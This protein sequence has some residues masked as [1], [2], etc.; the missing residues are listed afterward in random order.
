MKIFLTGFRKRITGTLLCFLIIAASVL[1]SSFSCAAAVTE[2]SIKA[3]ENQISEAKKE[4]DSLK[5][6]KTDL[7]KIKKSL[8]AS[9]SD[10][11]RFITDLDSQLTD[12]QEKIDALLDKIDQKERQIEKTTEELKEAE[13]IQQAQYEAMKKRIKFM[14]ERGDTLYFE[15]LLQSGSFSEMLNKADYIEMLSAYDRQKLNEYITTTELIRLTKEALEEEK[16]TLDETKAAEE[17]EEANLQALMD[18]KN[19]ELSA[20][21]TDISNKEAAIA[22]YE[23]EIKAENEAIAALER[24]VAADKAALYSRYMYDGGMFTWPAPGYTRISDD[25]GMRVHPTL[26]VQKMHNGIDLAAPS[27]SPV[28]AAYNGTVVAA[29]YNSSMGNYVMINH[30]GGLYTIYMHMSALYVSKGQDVTSGTKIGAVGSTGRSTGPHLHFGV[31]LNGNYVSP[32]G[33]LK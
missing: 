6:A 23:A 24:E 9:K 28:L 32:W 27:G 29:D 11:N 3:K 13:E 15:L 2:E 4:R 7:E 31:R 18:T 22:E 25:Y 19:A 10:L 33:Y 5:N 26:G 12:I 1:S 21:K 20:V 16:R 30:G 8:E 14:Y 17:E